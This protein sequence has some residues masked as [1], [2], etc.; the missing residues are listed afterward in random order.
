MELLASIVEP[1]DMPESDVDAMQMRMVDGWTVLP[2][3]LSP[4][5]S[6]TPSLTDGRSSDI[7]ELQSPAPLHRGFNITSPS[8]RKPF[9]PSDMGAPPSSS[10]GVVVSLL[11][12]QT[13]SK[14]LGQNASGKD[15]GNLS[16]NHRQLLFIGSFT[17]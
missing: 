3:P 2:E 17:H 7:D 14:S 8:T 15:N 6:P 10:C 12:A 5:I 11:P 4:L 16:R 9:M 1:V 13:C